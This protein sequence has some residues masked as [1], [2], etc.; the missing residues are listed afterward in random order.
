MRAVMLRAPETLLAQRRLIGADRWDEMWEGVLHMV[1]PPSSRHQRFG[2]ELLS[3]L[4]P[5]AQRSGLE[6]TYE[7]GVFRASAGESD[8]RVPDLVCAKPERFS[9]RGVE[10]GAELVVEI[11]SPD[12]ESR[13]K[14]SFYASVGVREVWVIDPV[15]RSFEVYV[16]RGESHFLAVPDETG[17]VHS[18]VL[19]VSLATTDQTRLRLVWDGGKA[20]V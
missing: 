10:H 17:A 2:A 3:I 6:A 7:T 5:I 18:T 9:E 20:A 19:P 14:L 12:D 15:T 16:L 11:L 1:P 8:Y 13:G 4:R